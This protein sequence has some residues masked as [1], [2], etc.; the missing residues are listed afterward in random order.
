MGK[1]VSDSSPKVNVEV[2]TR[3]NALG[4]TTDQVIHLDLP[5]STQL[6]YVID[7]VISEI[8]SDM[9]F[10]KEETEQ[11]NLAVIEA[12]MNAIKHGNGED[13]SKRTRFEFILNQ[14]QLTVVVEDQGV[15]FNRDN[16]ADP[17]DPSNLLKSS[18]RGIFLMETCMD[19]VTFEASGRIVRMVKLR[20]ATD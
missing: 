16:V 15:G 5:S 7:A 8:A 3:R 2:S 4:K 9:G 18:G 14:E 17:L 13:S 11:I 1:A 12:A 19:S 6:V 10:D 20:S